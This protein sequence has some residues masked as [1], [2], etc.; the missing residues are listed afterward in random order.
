VDEAF[1]IGRSVTVGVRG[2]AASEH[3]AISRQLDPCPCP[4]NGARPDVIIE[5]DWAGVGALVD[6][7]RD[8]GDGRVT[9][10]DGRRFYVLER[11]RACSVPPFDGAR[12]VRFAVQPGFPIGRAFRWLVR[13]ALHVALMARGSLAVHAAAVEIDGGAVLVA[14]WS[15]SGKT[16]TALALVERGA[17]FLSDKWTVVGSDGTAGVFPTS[18]GI[19]GWVLPYLPRLNAALRHRYRSRLRTAAAIRSVGRPLARGPMVGMTERLISRADRVGVPP[20]EVRRLY[21]HDTGARW[22]APLAAV[23][24]ITTV[25]A[26]DSIRAAFVDADWA[27]AR[28]SVTASFERR[29][30]FELH[31]RAQWTTDGHAP[32]LRSSLIARERSLLAEL[33]RSVPIIG[34]H[35]PF[36]TD[37]RPVADAIARLL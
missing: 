7:Q 9:A 24:L 21:G 3:R 23:A 16:E 4:G 18:V 14:G 1:E 20:S 8:A 11:N 5:S 32:D 17:R 30:M 6:I 37:P 15:E 34:V 29:P 36:P 22:H 27:A 12:P 33:L 10:S 13:P 25:P 26:H 28:L 31:D 35:A 19:R 2:L